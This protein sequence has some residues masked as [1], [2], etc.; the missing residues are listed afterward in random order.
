[1]N[2]QP[3]FDNKDRDIQFLLKKIIDKKQ[4]GDS[5][6]FDDMLKNL[7][8]T[9]DRVDKF[10]GGEQVA[11][12][13]YQIDPE[14]RKNVMEIINTPGYDPASVREAQRQLMMM[15][16]GLPRFPKP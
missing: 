1:M 5:G 11:L 3:N 6:K 8:S 15:N 12:H 2:S 16:Q 9:G 13:D 10:L 4:G 7:P 14:Y